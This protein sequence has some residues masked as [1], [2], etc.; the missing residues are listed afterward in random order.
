[1]LNTGMGR[2]Y[3]VGPRQRPTH[4]RPLL[5]ALLLALTVAL[6][7]CRG[8]DGSP[9]AERTPSGSPSPSVA[10]G[11]HGLLVPRDQRLFLRDMSTEKE[12]VLKRAEANVFYTYPRWSPDGSR[13][14]YALDVTYTGLPNQNWGSDIAVTRVDGSEPEQI[15]FRRPSPGVRVEGMAWSPDGR[16]LYVSL[17][18]TTIKDGRFLGQTLNLERIEPATGAREV[19]VPNAAY[20]TVSPDGSL[21]A[22]ITFS[23]ADDTGGL[24]VARSDGSDRRLIVPATGKYV[25]VTHPR[26]SPDGATLAFSAA[27]FASGSE[28]PNPGGAPAAAG[29]NAKPIAAHGLPQDIWLIPVAGGEPTRLTNMLEDEPTVAWSPDG[30]RL[31]IIATGGLYVVDVAGGEPRKIGLGGNL[32]QIDWR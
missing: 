23:S 28:A 12:Y 11:G 7:A 30:T 29:L 4:H 9:A 24:W 26:F 16:F 14:A 15:V 1:M 8:G 27:T 20:P 13:I 22:Y 17:M 31:A 3:P 19:I 2:R 6:G 25:S 10:A 21:I 32:A 18:E 5:F